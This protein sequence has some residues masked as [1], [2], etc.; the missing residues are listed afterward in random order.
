MLYKDPSYWILS[1]YI[2]LKQEI[3]RGLETYQLQIAVDALY[4]FLWNDYAAWYLEYLKTETSQLAFG[5][6]LFREFVVLASPYIPFETQ[7]LWQDFF[8]ESELLVNE[9]QNDLWLVSLPMPK[10]NN[11]EIIVEFISQI[12]SIKGVFGLDPAL[13]LPIYSNFELLFEYKDFIKMT[14]KGEI[15]K[16]EKPELYFVQNQNYSY[17]LP[18]KD[19]IADL[20]KEIVRTN[21]LV[22]SL[23]KQIMSLQN[24]LNNPKFVENAQEQVILEKEKDLKNRKL[25]LTQQIAKLEYLT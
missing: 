1:K 9:I 15:I 22:E 6:A 23:T 2:N 10:Q 4:D 21:K 19:K 11:F 3:A 16:E 14:T 8:K 5:K 20:P 18:I 7:A 12:R 24:Q 13:S 17:S 25:E